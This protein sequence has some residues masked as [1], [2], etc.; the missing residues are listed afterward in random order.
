MS[1]REDQAPEE[2]GAPPPDDDLDAEIDSAGEEKM[3]DLLK[4]A[5]GREQPPPPQTDV[6]RGVQKRL[7]ERSGGKFYD[8]E[9]S[10]AKQPPIGTYLVTSAIMLAIVLVTY[11]ILHY[12]SGEA[13]STTMEPAPVRIVFPKAPPPQP[14]PPPSAK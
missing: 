1:E 7:R 12:Q 13:V 6:L 3:R 5:L 14:A 9:W 10:T 11:A 2:N 4:G 8:D